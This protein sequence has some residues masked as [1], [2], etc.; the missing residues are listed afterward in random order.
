MG[1]KPFAQKKPWGNFQEFTKNQKSTVKILTVEPNQKL[2]LQLHKK[3][4]EFWKVL[5]GPCIIT[6]GDKRHKAKEGDEFVIPKETKHRLEAL[7]NTAKV[8][9]ISLGEFDEDDIK[10]LKDKYKRNE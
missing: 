2:S 8:L 7:E 4:E 10:R 5:K 1:V 3:R 6:I 9:E